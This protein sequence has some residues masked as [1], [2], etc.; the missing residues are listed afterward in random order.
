MTHIFKHAA[1][2][3]A[4]AAAALALPVCLIPTAAFAD[5]YGSGYRSVSNPHEAC[6]RDEQQDKVVGALIGGVIGGVLG[7][8]IA[9]DN[10][11]TEGSVIG[12]GVG[13]LA[14]AGIADSQTDCDP[15]YKPHYN[16]QNTTYYG[17]GGYQ[18]Q[19]VYTQPRQVYTQPQ[20]VYNPPRQVYTSPQ[21]VYTPPR[22][23][24]QSPRQD[25]G[26][27]TYTPTRPVYTTVQTYPSYKAKP[28]KSHKH[29]HKDRSYHRDVYR[30]PVYQQ[31]VRHA[32]HRSVVR[33]G[34]HYH[35]DY[36]C[37]GS[38]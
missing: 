16:R 8:Q 18:Q 11:R 30:T 6:E 33:T 3:T 10:A 31:P 22:T 15:R 4:L 9:S 5:S 20:P 25:S 36:I 2:K 19:P 28:H 14:G 17:D 24:Y 38:H 29:K 12:I 34:T 13:A 7:N 21:P 1:R 37:H 26:Y 23:V 27:R 35:G 32:S